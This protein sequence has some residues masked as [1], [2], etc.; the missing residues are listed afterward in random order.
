[1][2]SG[3]TV[4]SL[5]QIPTGPGP[6]EPHD[7]DVAPPLP[8]LVAAILAP[9]AVHAVDFAA[10]GWNGSFDTTLSFGQTWRE[11]SRD[12]R[13]IGTADGGSGRSP[14]IDDGNLNYRKGRA[15]SAYKA[16]A[17]LSLDRG[18]NF[19]V[20]V[21]GSALYDTLVEDS[22]TDRTP[23]SETGKDLA[24]SYLRLLEAFV[25]G[26]WDLGGHDLDWHVGR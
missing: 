14:N 2:Q 5:R 22:N 19:G 16:V 17:E 4:I 3:S 8:A 1:M 11:E 15:S 21:R 18:E 9:A 23:I 26:R 24:G 25:W 10:G 13:L 12:P 7:Q 20:F 6:G